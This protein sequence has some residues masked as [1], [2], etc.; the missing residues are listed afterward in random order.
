VIACALP[1]GKIITTR[2]E[3][4]GIIVPPQGDGGFGYDPIFFS[5]DYGKTMA[6]LSQEEKNKISHRGIALREMVALL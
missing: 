6:Q 5:P 2:G 4:A 1:S 3:T